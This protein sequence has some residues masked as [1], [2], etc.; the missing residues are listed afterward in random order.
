MWVESELERG[1]TFYFSLPVERLGMNDLEDAWW[2]EPPQGARP[3]AGDPPVLLAVTH[4]ATAAALFSRYIR[5]FRPV[6]VSDLQQASEMAR[7]LMPQVMVVDQVELDEASLRLTELVDR[8]AISRTLF[9]GCPLRP[10]NEV[11]ARKEIEAHLIKPVSRE[12]VWDIIRQHKGIESVLVVDDDHDFVLLLD[13][14]LR[15]DPVRSCQVL[16]AYTGHEAL[17]MV[18]DH[19]PDLILLDLGLPDM[20]GYEVV[21]RIR[22]TEDG[23]HTPIV[24]VS[25]QDQMLDQQVLSG[26]IT[27][28]ETGGMTTAQMMQWIQEIADRAVS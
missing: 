6:V 27:I 15:D 28:S 4:S 9:V 18:H 2:D 10:R 17:M 19:H 12:S 25:G 22:A 13:R 14:M 11:R 16:S 20:D 8:W 24:I 3:E 1:S 7:R 5:G 23:H 26:A 21:D